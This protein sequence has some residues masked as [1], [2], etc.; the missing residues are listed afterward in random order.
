MPLGAPV[1]G[2]AGSGA[3][4]PPSC[5]VTMSSTTV[6]SDPPSGMRARTSVPLKRNSTCGVPGILGVATSSGTTPCGSGPGVT[7]ARISA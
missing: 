2:S 4:E 1:S 6:T 7:A 3:H 5:L